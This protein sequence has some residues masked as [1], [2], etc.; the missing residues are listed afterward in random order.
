VTVLNLKRP[1]K[2]N[3]SVSE[4]H[5]RV[6]VG[7]ME[8]QNLPLDKCD[9][10]LVGNRLSIGWVKCFESRSAVVLLGDQRLRAAPVGVL[11]EASHRF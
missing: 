10:V 9:A 7:Q 2:L 1:S 6:E 8:R 3:F 4:Q 11:P 5:C